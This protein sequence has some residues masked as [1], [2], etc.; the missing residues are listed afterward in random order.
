MLQK[1]IFIISSFL[2]ASCAINREN[3]IMKNEE[4]IK[5]L[6]KKVTMSFWRKKT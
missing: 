3:Q 2:F 5:K 4:S 6:I 1:V